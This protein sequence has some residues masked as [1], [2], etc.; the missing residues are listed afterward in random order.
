[1]IVGKFNLFH[2][3]CGELLREAVASQ[4]EEGKLINEYMR[5]GKIVPARITCGLAKNTME[6]NGGKVNDIL[7]K[8]EK[9][10]L[11]RWVSKK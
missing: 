10:L 8:L 2:F 4:N 6:K 5:E 3:S 1:M 9:R 11:D 7:N